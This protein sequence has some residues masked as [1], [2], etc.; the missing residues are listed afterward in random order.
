[1]VLF[2]NGDWRLRNL[3][4][5]GTARYTFSYGKKGDVAVAGDWN[6]DGRDRPGLY[7]DGKWFYRNLITYGSSKSFTFGEPKSQPV[8]W[9]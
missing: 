5:A 3:N 8:V 1:V 7:R 4:S 2:R 6:R 9:R